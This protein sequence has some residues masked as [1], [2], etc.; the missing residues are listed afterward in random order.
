MLCTVGFLED[1]VKVDIK[2]LKKIYTSEIKLAFKNK[3]MTGYTEMGNRM[4]LNNY[5]R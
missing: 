2:K 1:L 4:P 5:A 3:V